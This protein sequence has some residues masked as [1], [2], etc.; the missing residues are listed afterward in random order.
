MKKRKF[1]PILPLA[2]CSVDFQKPCPYRVKVVKPD[3]RT[4]K[5]ALRFTGYVS[6]D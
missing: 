2:Y 1:S 3:N 5:K 4:S 6:L